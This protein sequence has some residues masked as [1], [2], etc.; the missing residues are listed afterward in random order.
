MG[1]LLTDKPFTAV[2]ASGTHLLQVLIGQYEFLLVF[3]LAGVIILFLMYHS[4][5]KMAGSK[6]FPDV[7]CEE[8]VASVFLRLNPAAHICFKF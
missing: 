1:N 5:P 7:F 2:L 3:L 8:K 4:Q 6:T